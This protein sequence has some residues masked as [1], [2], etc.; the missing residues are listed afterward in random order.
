[1]KSS[2]DEASPHYLI[3]SVVACVKAGPDLACPPCMGTVNYHQLLQ[4]GI[5]KLITFY[6]AAAASSILCT[7]SSLPAVTISFFAAITSL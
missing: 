2:S 4:Y 6:I 5:S 3:P 7:L 1:M